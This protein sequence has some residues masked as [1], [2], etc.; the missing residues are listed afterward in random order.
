MYHII[1]NAE[2]FLADARMLKSLKKDTFKKQK[3]KVVAKLQRAFEHL[4][5][6][7]FFRTQYY[8][9]TAKSL[10]K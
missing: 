2:S 6:I 4:A 8:F 1:F 9:D 10:V 3:Y 5:R 7:I